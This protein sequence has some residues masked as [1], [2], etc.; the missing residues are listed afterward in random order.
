VGI[1]NTELVREH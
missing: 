1:I